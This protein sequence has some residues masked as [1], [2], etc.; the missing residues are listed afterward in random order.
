MKI[1]ENIPISKLT[2]MRLGGPARYVVE[3]ETS[4]DVKKVFAFAEGEKSAVKDKTSALRTLSDGEITLE[5]FENLPVFPLGAGAN[6]IGRDDGF[7][8]VLILDRIKGIEV[9]DETADG[10]LV[11]AGGGEVWDDFVQFC[12]EREYSGVE[13]MSGIPGLVGSAPVQ[14]IGAYGQEVASV[15]D[16]VEAYDRQTG[17]MVVLTKDEMQMGY[18]T[19]IFNSGKDQGRYFITAVVFSLENREFLK[20]PFYAS[21]QVY[22][23][24]QQGIN[25][26][27][28]SDSSKTPKTSETSKT[29]TASNHPPL[30]EIEYREYSPLEIRAA[31]LAVRGSKLPDPAEKPSAG[32]FFKNVYLSESEAEAARAKGLKVYEKPGSSLKNAQGEPL[33]YMVNSGYLIQ[34]RGLSGQLLHGMRVNEKAALVLIN[35]SAKSYEDLAAARSEIRNAVQEK[36]GYVLEQEPVEIAAGDTRNSFSVQTNVNQTE[37][38]LRGAGSAAE[39]TNL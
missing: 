37:K 21:L 4:E 22:L 7:D 16:H 13:A 14:N 39:G 30:P 3:V 8:G 25:P 23:A 32:S 34:D 36:F 26:A 9:L 31:V 19:T 24:E 27:K 33:K 29:L 6:S 17:E 11:R 28:S 5:T 15:I 18:R 38:L 10:V 2:T 12:C 1:R 35:E 20:P